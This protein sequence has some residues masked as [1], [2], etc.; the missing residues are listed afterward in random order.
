M[1]PV[2]A[3]LTD[4]GLRDHY[5]GT[6]KGV[7]LGIC[8][9]A[10]LV[11]ISHECRRTTCWQAR[12]SSR[13]PIGTFRRARSSWSSSIPEWD[14]RGAGSPPKRATT[15]SWRPDNGVLSLVL[16]EQA[17][18]KAHRGAD[19]AAVRAAD[20]EPDVRGARPVRAGGRLA[21]RR[22]STL[23]ALGRPAGS[24]VR[25]ATC[26]QPRRRTPDRHRRRGRARGPVRQ[27]HHEHRSPDVRTMRGR[28][29]VERVTSPARRVSARGRRP[30]PT[31]A[32]GELCA[33]FGSTDHLEIAA[34]GDE[35]RGGHSV[36]GGGARRARYIAPCVIAMPRLL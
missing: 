26:P 4:F 15:A 29:P 22:A 21:G 16:D 3:L 32:P 31:R 18:P 2:I 11:D 5:A 20:R 25:A 35:R 13:R 7:V 8:P 17:A 14:R 19:R 24:I 23:T 10:T 34:R 9:D 6:M 12:W 36:T 28:R 1:R 30:T 27:P 33:L